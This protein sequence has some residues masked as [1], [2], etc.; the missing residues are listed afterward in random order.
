MFPRLSN[1]N[2]IKHTSLPQAVPMNNLPRPSWYQF[3]R[4]SVALIVFMTSACLVY[5]TEKGNTEI[6]VNP[7]TVPEYDT[8]A[9][10]VMY[11]NPGSSSYDQI[12]TA[13]VNG[14]QSQATVFLQTNNTG[15]QQ[16]MINTFTAHGVPM[17]NIVFIEVYG[18]RIWIRDHG[19]FS[20]YDDGELAFVGFDDL[21]TGHADQDLP[22]RLANYWNLNYYDFSHIIFDGGNY[23]V[24]S[25]N[26]MF[27]TDRL[28]TNNPSIATEEIDNILETYMGITS[29]HTFSA[30]SNDYW[31]HLDM[32]VK[33]LNDTTFIISTVDPWHDD[34]PILQDNL[35]ILHSLEHPED[36]TY[37][38][39][40]IPKAQNWKTYINSLI[41]NDAVLVPI[42]NDHRDV[43]ALS[44]YEALMPG[45]TIIGID[46]NAMIGW[47][48]AIHC[49]TNQLP[50]FQAIDDQ[51]P[52]TIS[53]SVSS[54]GGI[55]LDNAVIT[56]NG[57]QNTPGDYEFIDQEPGTY[58]F[59]V[60]HLCNATYSGEITVANENINIDVFLA[61]VAGD[62]NGDE[63]VDVLDV[64]AITNHFMGNVPEPFCFDNADV[65]NDGAIDVLDVIG[66]V[67]IFMQ[68]GQDPF[69]TTGTESVSRYSPDSTTRNQKKAVDAIRI[70][71]GPDPTIGLLSFNILEQDDYVVTFICPEGQTVR[72]VTIPA[73][74]TG[75][76]D[77]PVD[78]RSMQESHYTIRI[79]GKSRMQVLEQ[80]IDLEQ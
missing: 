19:P 40:Q 57:Q 2:N 78:R 1:T 58:A 48:G 33:L 10:V 66:T 4:L 5:A 64:A 37:Q 68:G 11:W 54:T 9:G 23:L 12:V 24:D 25:H 73:W 50:P 65:N 61:S 32:Q 43:T 39:A 47:E 8:I 27:A 77:I 75:T 30:L 79:T 35:A 16:N 3:Y 67:N 80:N 56:L 29:I 14:I 69:I 22:E 53:F 13:V 63:V 51:G 49:I 15:H 42:Y 17:D 28:Y 62:A 46:C 31:G 72:K 7:R 59:S 21:A 20:I 44:T 26:Q 45:K 70:I 55:P 71:D 52:F 41:V 6:P 36:K 76:Y 38:V 60:Q 34:Y 74:F 18:D